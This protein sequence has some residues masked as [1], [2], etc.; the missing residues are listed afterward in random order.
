MVLKTFS[1]RASSGETRSCRLRAPSMRLTVHGCLQFVQIIGTR[2]LISASVGLK[3]YLD[4]FGWLASQLNTKHVSAKLRLSDLEMST[5]CSA[6]AFNVDAS[7]IRRFELPLD[8]EISVVAILVLA[9]RDLEV[10]IARTR[11]GNV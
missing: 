9:K 5:E 2:R 11:D 6:M 3:S 1:H 7:A 8:Q 10:F 4:G